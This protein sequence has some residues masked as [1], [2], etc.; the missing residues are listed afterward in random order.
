MVNCMRSAGWRTLVLMLVGLLVISAMVLA[1][2]QTFIN[3]TGGTVTGIK[4][5]FSKS[6]TITRHDSVFPDQDPN[7]RSDE[8]T[9]SGGEL[10]NLGRFSITWI[11]SSGKVTRY[12]WIEKAQPEQTSQTTSPSG[13]QKP[14]LPDPNTPPILYGDDYPGSDEALYQP[15][16]DEQIWL[17]DLEGHGDI[18]HNDSI[19][20][21]YAPGFDK[22]QITRI[23]VYRNMIKLSFLPDKLDVLTNAQMKTFDGNWRE[24]SPASNH[25]DH[26][27][28]GYE[29]RFKIQTADHVWILEKTVK[30]G[31]HWHPKEFWVQIDTNWGNT[32]GYLSY[33]QILNFFQKI[34]KDGF[35][36]ISCDV[37]YYM[38]TPYDN[39]VLELPFRDDSIIEGIRTS[40]EAEMKTILK[41]ATEANLETH[42]RVRINLSLKYQKEHGNHLATPSNPEKF[43]ENYADLML[44]LVPL[45]NKYHVKL[46]TLFV[47]TEGLEKYPSLI[48][49]VYTA[50]NER[51][52]GEM[53][54]DESTNNILNGVSFIND[55]PIQTTNEFEKIVKDFTFWDWTDSHGR[56]MR[57]EYSGWGTPMETQRDQRV[58]VMEK[59]FVKFW[60]L[61]MDYYRSQ[62]PNNP[63]MFGE[64][65]TRD[66]DGQS[67][68]PDYYRIPASKRVLDGQEDADAWCAYLKGAQE[69]GIDSLNLWT[70]P[71]G[72]QWP[73][74][75]PGDH[76]INIGIKYPLSSAYRV[77]TAI[78]KPK[79]N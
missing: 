30:S 26:A 28:M 25:T 40:S 62:Y 78:I 66:A 32:L 13:T 20:I 73:M 55:K 76:Y 9:F 70:I 6:V 57:I 2:S 31:F 35:T 75:Y 7:G 34:K 12:E 69:L 49:E 5:E 59:N 79:G 18:Y 43:F 53:G 23:D 61:P 41:V 74:D 33:K 68:I 22:S 77:I 38:N 24:H 45:L 47:E 27:I 56:L 29:Y 48:K 50:I 36:G 10:R 17:T 14:G 8:F 71:L 63:Q 16:D 72:D 4:V 21:N 65:G 54:F 37:S 15:K 51:F 3:K 42:I 52:E 39:T 58:S 19:V 46:L 64:I 44:K 67:V 60:K 1:A 11:P